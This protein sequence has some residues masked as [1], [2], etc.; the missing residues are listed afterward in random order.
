MKPAR[1]TVNLTEDER[2]ELARIA[3]AQTRS[4][5]AQVR[6]YILEGMRRDALEEPKPGREGG[7]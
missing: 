4:V 2:R 3:G 1:I 7:E 5:A 6:R